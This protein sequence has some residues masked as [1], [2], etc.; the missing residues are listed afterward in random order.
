MT[1]DLAAQLKSLAAVARVE[2]QRKGQDSLLYD[3][4][5]AADIGIES[6]YDLAV[7]GAFLDSL[8]GNR[9]PAMSRRCLALRPP[10]CIKRFRT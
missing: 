7:Q 10:R 5:T 3:D 6:I 1:T 8:L 2:P 9:P 4:R